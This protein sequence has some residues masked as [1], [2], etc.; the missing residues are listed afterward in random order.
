MLLLGYSILYTEY[1]LTWFNHQEK[2][3]SNGD[4]GFRVLGTLVGIPNRKS[5]N[6]VGIS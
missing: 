6:V 5:E 4:W 3:Y 1:N 2:H